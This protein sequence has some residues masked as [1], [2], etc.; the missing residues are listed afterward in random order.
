MD[1][2]HVSADIAIDGFLRA[3]KDAAAE[4]PEFRARLIEALGFTVLYEGEEQFEGADPVRQAGLWS[5][6][7][8]AR[9]WSKATLKQ[10]KDAL[11]A[12]QLA[13]PE[14]MKGKK[15]PQLIGM[16]YD[17]ALKAYQ[18]DGKI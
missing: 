13:T 3:V 8:F 2:K 14:D 6:D 16:L 9:I 11:K 18:N 17:R 4:M 5:H 1:D 15:K 10:I 12:R 7:A